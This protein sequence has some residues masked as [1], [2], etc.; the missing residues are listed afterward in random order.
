MQ[1]EDFDEMLLARIERDQAWWSEVFLLAAG[2]VRKTP[3]NIA[4]LADSLLPSDPTDETMQPA[5]AGRAALVAQALAETDF[6]KKH[7]GQDR[8]ALC[9]HPAAQ[10]DL[11]ARRHARNRSP[12]G[13]RACQSGYCPGHARR[14]T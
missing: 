5:M 7:R 2:R 9:S 10:P 13:N 14:P 1:Q 4:D 11:A 12:A 3:R 6:A 8:W